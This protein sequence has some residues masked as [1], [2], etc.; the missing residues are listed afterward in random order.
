MHQNMTQRCVSK[1]P[2]R[3]NIKMM[4]V[5][6]NT[7]TSNRGIGD[8]GYHLMQLSDKEFMMEITRTRTM[9][10]DKFPELSTVIFEYNKQ[11]TLLQLEFWYQKP[12]PQRCERFFE[13][14]VMSL[15]DN[16]DDES[17]E[18]KHIVQLCERL[19]IEY[20][21]HKYTLPSK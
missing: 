4:A 12:L 1:C 17:E 18:G 5:K 6:K 7:G 10:Q 15:L 16:V 20:L 21:P 19:L 13:A 8:R 2:R 14:D 3:M 11:C 9:F